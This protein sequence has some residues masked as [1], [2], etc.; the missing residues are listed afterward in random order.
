MTRHYQNTA[1]TYKPA[2]IEALILRMVER[3]DPEVLRLA[4]SRSTSTKRL[5]ERVWQMESY[6]SL[7][8]FLSASCGL[9]P[10]A[11]QVTPQLICRN[12]TV[13]KV[14]AQL[15]MAVV[16][17]SLIMHACVTVIIVVGLA[18]ADVWDERLPGLLAARALQYGT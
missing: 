6:R 5:L 14:A 3:F 1:T 10:D 17:A 11:G 18:F 16:S 13:I 2:S 4:Q 8:S 7:T 12:L 15:L 9:S